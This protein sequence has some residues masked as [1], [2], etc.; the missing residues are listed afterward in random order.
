MSTNFSQ[1]ASCLLHILWKSVGDQANKTPLFSATQ[2]ARRLAEFISVLN[3]ED[4]SRL[5]CQDQ[6]VEVGAGVLMSLVGCK[7]LPV[8][9]S[10]CQSVFENSMEDHSRQDFDQARESSAS[11][12]DIC[13]WPLFLRIEFS[14][15]L[16]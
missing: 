7:I 10:G 1:V 2:I 12:N 4:V 5:Q 3:K 16:K 9:F 11:S 15:I 13:K 8:A 6:I 14:D